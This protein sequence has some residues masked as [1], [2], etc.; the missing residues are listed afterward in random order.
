MQQVKDFEDYCVD[1]KG[2]VY[3]FKKNRTLKGGPLK[4]QS[5]NG[6][7]FVFLRKNNISHQLSIHRIV[8]TTYI[9]NPHNFKEVNHIDGDR[10]NNSVGNLEWCDSAYNSW[11]RSTAFVVYK[12]CDS[13]A[14]RGAKCLANYLNVSTRAASKLISGKSKTCKGWSLLNIKGEA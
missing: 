6:Y 9:D 7:L 4:P 5:I 8:A 11:H 3:S 10:L 2:N 13:Y 1:T 14:G 12:G